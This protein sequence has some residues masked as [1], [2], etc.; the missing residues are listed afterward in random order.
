[1]IRAVRTFDVGLVYQIMTSPEIWAVV[2]E[3]GQD[4]MT[5]TPDVTSACYL[6]VYADES[7]VALYIFRR[8]NGVTLEGHA[9]V[10]P[11]YRKRYSIATGEKVLEWVWANAPWCHKINAWVPTIYPNVRDFAE[12]L[13][14]QQEGINSQSY[15]KNGT[16]HDRW[17]LGLTRS[18]N[19]G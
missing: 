5:Y 12:R 4:A 14:F 18:E 3:D 15:L 13:G 1:M 19:D 2:A 8:I 9:Q 10:L 16:L 17:L 11:Q 7:L 6:A